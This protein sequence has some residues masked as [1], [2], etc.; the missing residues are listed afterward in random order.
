M[1]NLSVYEVWCM[2]S[3]SAGRAWCYYAVAKLKCARF[4]PKWFQFA[5]FGA[6]LFSSLI[7][8]QPHSFVNIARLL[9]AA[10]P[11][12]FIVFHHP[13]DYTNRLRGRLHVRFCVRIAVRFRVRF[14]A[15]CGLLLNLGSIFPEMCLATVVMYVLKTQTIC[16]QMV[17][18]IVWRIGRV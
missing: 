16:M 1:C 14:P 9:V 13:T 2:S 15:K 6:F 4:C 18:G 8:I 11:H 7:L 12:P 17:R 10:A 3:L 5:K